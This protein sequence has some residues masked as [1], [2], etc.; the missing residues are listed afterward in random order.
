MK[1]FD[2]ATKK[3]GC[4]RI[5]SLSIFVLLGIS[6]ILPVANARMYQWEQPQS[7]VIQLSGNA[8]AWYRS[9]HPGPRVLVFDNG[10]LIDDTAVSVTNAQR[11]ALREKALGERIDELAR[12]K[13]GMPEK[14]ATFENET[15]KAALAEAAK[16]GI[17]VE[18]LAA[19]ASDAADAENPLSVSTVQATVEELKALL[20]RWDT[21]KSNQA[22]SVLNNNDSNATE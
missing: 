20:S 8:P 7:G 3:P 12:E 5:F 4:S 13:T 19:Q 2:I 11:I 9:V 21:A 14:N 17:D 6:V 18:E 15:L 1:L 10:K 16:S 22:R